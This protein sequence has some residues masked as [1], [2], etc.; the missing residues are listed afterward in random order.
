MLAGCGLRYLNLLD[1]QKL[2]N[3]KGPEGPFYLDV[4][5][6]L[7]KSYAYFLAP[8]LTKP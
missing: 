2:D 6:T 4:T 8:V 5:L 1:L 7:R 3:K